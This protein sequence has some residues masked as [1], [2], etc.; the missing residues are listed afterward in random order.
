L[1][2]SKWHARLFSL[3]LGWFFL[4]CVLLLHLLH[5]SAVITQGVERTRA[6]EP[7]AI[8]A[9]AFVLAGTF[10]QTAAPASRSNPATDFLIKAGRFLFAF[11]MAIFGMQH[12]QYAPFIAT[13]I[14]AWIPGHIFWVYFTGFGFIAAAVAISLKILGRLAAISLGL[15]FLLWFLVLHMPRVFADPRNGDE[16]SSAFIALCLAGAC[17]FIATT[18]P[19]QPVRDVSR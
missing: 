4:F 16:W 14:P 8:A 2:L 9:A 1:R 7:L 12:F 3:L 19:N 18:I 10:P 17:L 15:M 5:F 11:T 13:L 6:L